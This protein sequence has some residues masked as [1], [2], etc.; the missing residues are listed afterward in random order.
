[1]KKKLILIDGN[2]LIHRAY[3]ALPPLGTATGEKTHAVYGFT[4]M[5]LRLLDE[6]RPDYLAV[7]FDKGR[8][9]F[10]TQRYAL[11]KAQRDQAPEDL[12][13]Q[14]S[15]ARE[16]LTTF[17]IPYFELAGF[18]ADDILGTL[19]AQA[20]RDGLKTLIVTGDRD[21]LQLV[22]ENTEVLLTRRGITD[23][24]RLDEA[25]V[26]EK[27]GVTPLQVPDYKALTGDASDNI[28]GVPGIGPKTAAGFLSEFATLEDLYAHLDTVKERWQKALREN[29]QQVYLSRDLATIDR[30]VPLIAD[31]KKCRREKPAR[32]QVEPLFR[33]LE[34][35]SILKRLFPEAEGAAKKQVISAH[36]Q[37]LTDQAAVAGWV[38]RARAAGSLSFL[39][40]PGRGPE[41]AGVAVAAGAEVAF[42]PWE[43]NDILGPLLED[44]TLPKNTHD[45][46]A[47]LNTLAGAGITLAGVTGDTL[48]AGYLLDPTADGRELPRLAKE[49]LG[50]D[51]P[52][53]PSGRHGA[54][55]T[56]EC[57]GVFCAWVQAL[58]ALW[59]RLAEHLRT[60]DLW[61]LY[62]EVEL[63]L[64]GVLAE[65]E[66]TGIK[67]DRERLLRM[68]QAI[69]ERMAAL[70]ADIYE[71]VGQEFNL[72]SP[73]QLAVILFD[74][75]GLP[76]KKKTK[77]GYSTDAEVLEELAPAHPAV[78]K[79]LEHR[80]LAKLKSTYVD[81]MGT[82]INPATGRIHTTFTQTVTATGRLSS[83]EPNLQNIPIRLE[84]GRRLREAFV[85]G[86]P[87]WRILAADYS[88]IE[89]R[90]L[91]HVAG[92]AALQA[93]FQSEEDIHTRTAAEI[94]HIPIAEVTPELRAR[95][96]AVNFGIVYGISDF[97]LA[98]N[99]GVPREEARQ[100]IE[101]YLERYPG[102]RAYMKR[103]V[104]GARL[105]GYVT[106]I[107][108][109][110]R[111]LPDITSRNW[112]RRSF[113]ERTALNTPIQGSAADVIKV[114]M[115][116]VS[117]ALK[118][119]HLASRLLL[120]VHDELVFET[121]PQE[122]E[123][124]AQVVRRCME[125]AVEL[126]VPLKVD[127]K[128]GP[129]WYQVERV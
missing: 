82:Q 65:M 114:A 29:E 120:Q 22:N 3:H 38:E 55:D 61:P 60:D 104:E 63:P 116:K 21:A 52:R 27:L 81:A 110:R 10:R 14:F 127:I 33:R 125:H 20:E 122:V 77:T 66:R 129:N 92:D 48:L 30:S 68:G 112:A 86:E 75:L 64:A 56:S 51:L 124:L 67:V 32:D 73:K 113:A 47:A 54:D 8:E 50:Q 46:K 26:K 76:A 12:V 7:A 1:M 39:L 6:E 42:V 44:V 96:K 71:Q 90:I 16:V 40:V 28:P 69:G 103:V 36:Y 83:V 97:G 91:A 80:Q 23:L 35:H 99:T 24:E 85:P 9:T 115:L 15:L 31:W 108:G 70:E 57:E 49:Y 121:P 5:L 79:I 111:Y 128:V 72:N 17:N 117:R 11:Y 43:L 101:N 84:L 102:V 45:V 2:S 4:T 78:A 107:L 37:R 98:Q 123:V 106:T 105:S 34:F 41:P 58:D 94:F 19:A 126:S 88:Q 59:Q 93:A 95:A 119:Q 100:Y 89:L 74:K 18:E 53:L 13:S 87:D 109:R 62:Q 118:E 25:G